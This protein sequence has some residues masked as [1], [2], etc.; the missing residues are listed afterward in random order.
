MCETLYFSR[1]VRH[2][3]V[4]SGEA[5]DEDAIRELGRSEG[6]LTLLD[7]AREIVMLGDTSI[8]ELIRVT[9]TE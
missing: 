1:D 4:Q 5:I 2:M 9:S 6:M 3:I 8:E 7:S